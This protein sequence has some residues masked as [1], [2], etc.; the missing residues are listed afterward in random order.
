MLDAAHACQITFDSLSLADANR[1]AEELE[2]DLSR[3]ATDVQVQRERA[4]P[5]S[6]DLGS[7]LLLALTTPSVVVAVANIIRDFLKRRPNAAVT[8]ETPKGKLSLTGFTS[9]DAAKLVIQ[10]LTQE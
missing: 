10:Y 7:T 8:I 4:N 2:A 9:E 5:Q 3:A 1:Y 6:M